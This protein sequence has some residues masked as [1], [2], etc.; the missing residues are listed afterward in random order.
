MD[1]NYLD[2]VK[3]INSIIETFYAVISGE[4]DENHNWELFK[5]LFHPQ[6]KLIQYAKNKEGIYKTTF[7]SPEDYVN[8][9]GK[10]LE[11]VGFYEKEIYKKV[12]TYGSMAHVLSTYESYRSKFDEKPYFTGLNSFQILYKDKRWW[13]LNNF[14]TRETP[15]NPI[16][17]EYLSK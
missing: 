4:K 5:F 12:D 16:P 6:G 15:D 8:T 2:K 10:Y 9:T 13:I 1:N 7:F 14:W 3:S 17:K 11:K